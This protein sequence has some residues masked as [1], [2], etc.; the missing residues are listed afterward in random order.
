MSD[1]QES[2]NSL[3]SQLLFGLIAG[4]LAALLIVAAFGPSADSLTIGNADR[5]VM[6][7]GLMSLAAVALL[8]LASAMRRRSKPWW[9]AV[10]TVNVVQIVRFLAALVAMAAASHGGDS[11]GLLW[12]LLMVPLLGI[13]LA[14]G[15][16]MA[17]REARRAQRRRLARAG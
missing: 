15:L 6:A 16:A 11:S 13:L 17:L 7:I 1:P 12:A 2:A 8:F 9:I 3:T 10:I 4:N 14:A 5:L